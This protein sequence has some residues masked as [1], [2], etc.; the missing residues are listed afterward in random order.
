MGPEGFTGDGDGYDGEQEQGLVWT[1][2]CL[3]LL[4]WELATG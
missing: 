2:S 4:G 1:A 3:G